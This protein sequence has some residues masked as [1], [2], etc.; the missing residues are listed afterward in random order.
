[1][2]NLLSYFCITAIAGF[3]GTLSLS[4]QT[5]TDGSYSIPVYVTN[6]ALYGPAYYTIYVGISGVNNS[7]LLP[8]MIDTGSPN[9]FSVAGT[10]GTSYSD[11]NTNGFFD[12]SGNGSP[13]YWYATLTNTISL[14]SSN[15]TTYAATATAV[16]WA[17]VRYI[18]AET[19]GMYTFSNAVAQ[20]NSVTDRGNYGNFGAGLYGSSTLATILTQ[21]PLNSGLKVG[22][23]MNFTTN[24]T[25]SG[26]GSLTL[27][28]STDLLNTLSNMPGAIIL[29]MLPSGT[30]LP[31]ATG[32]VPGYQ[33]AQ[34]SNVA[35][36]LTKDSSTITTNMP[37]VLD[38]GGGSNQIIYDTNTDLAPYDHATNL[39]VSSIS[40]NTQTIYGISSN[41]TAWGGDVSLNTDSPYGTRINSGGYFFGSNIV[42]FDLADGIVII[43]PV[44]E[45]SSIWFF[46]LGGVC[47]I[48]YG[49]CHKGRPSQK[50]LATPSR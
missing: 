29:S 34:V 1:M 47:L 5:N 17:Q 13:G 15:Q 36:T 19:N 39:I 31:T 32:T 28:L 11:T 6:P 48:S 21:L 22:Y 20:S 35:V 41:T 14:G 16:D 42:T 12:F 30:N 18:S 50:G 26:T 3:L 24:L 27:G 8:Y 37:F 49:F 43:N 4:A 45:P 38:T 9:F 2:N 7:A 44:P 46:L 10:G 40:S 33:R 23:S 25:V